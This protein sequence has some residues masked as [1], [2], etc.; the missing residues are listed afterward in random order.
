MVEASGA[1]TDL[2]HVATLKE[3]AR[4]APT[5]ARENFPTLIR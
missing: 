1:P 3:R 2:E 4:S 5:A